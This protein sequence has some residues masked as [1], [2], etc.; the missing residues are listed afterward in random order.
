MLADGVQQRE[1]SEIGSNDVWTTARGKDKN[2]AADT[3]EN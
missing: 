2:N 3:Q 1:F